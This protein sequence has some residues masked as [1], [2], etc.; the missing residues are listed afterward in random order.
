MDN[1]P[2]WKRKQLSEMTPEEWEKCCDGCGQCCLY[3]L[4][5]EDSGEIFLTCVACRY[6]DL[7]ACRCTAYGDRAQLMPTCVTLT[8]GLVSQLSWLPETCAYRLLAAGKELP[9]W[10]WLITSDPQAVHQAGI[11]VRD[12]AIPQEAAHMDDLGIYV[13]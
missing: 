5:D 9:T 1:D 2:F 4:E 10:H 3:K 6:L 8:L 11:S 12:Y 13:I 7:Q